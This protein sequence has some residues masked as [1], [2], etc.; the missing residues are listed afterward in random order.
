MI[1]NEYVKQDEI[2]VVMIE[3]L[4]PRDRLLRKV[5]KVIDFSF[6]R[7]RMEPLNCKDNGRPAIDPVMLFKMLF[8]G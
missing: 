3:Q 1:K 6:V 2:E 5:D 8:I 7:Q 4:V